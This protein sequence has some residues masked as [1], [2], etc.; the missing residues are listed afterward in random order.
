MVMIEV[1]HRD[2]GWIWTSGNVLM[3]LER[4]IPVPQQNGDAVRAVSAA[5]H[6]YKVHL[7]VLVPVHRSHTN[8]RRTSGEITMRTESTVSGVNQNGNSVGAV[9]DRCQVR[10]V[11]AVEVSDDQLCRS[12]TDWITV[13]AKTLAKS[14]QRQEQKSR[15]K[16]TIHGLLQIVGRRF[17][18]VGCTS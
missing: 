12:R 17:S 2:R 11:I 8:W 5:V 6:H 14:G 4:A 7:A 9:V 15:K 3:R 18:A 13:C 16:K 1:A 10:N